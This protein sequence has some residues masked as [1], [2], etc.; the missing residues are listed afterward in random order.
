M[1]LSSHAIKKRALELGFS[2][3][4]VVP[5][6]KLSLESERLRRWL[7]RGF[8]GTM[9]WIAHSFEKRVDPFVHMPD[10]R[11]IVCVALNYYTDHAMSD[12]PGRGKVSRYAWGDDY[13]DIVG[14]RL[15]TLLSWIQQEEP[16]SHGKIAIDTSPVMD[17]AWAAKAGLG[18]IGKHSNLI[19]T[20]FG[21]WV[22]LGE[23]LLNL[24][25]DY[26]EQ[27]IADQCGTCTACL[28]ACPTGA[29]VEPYVVDSNHC[30]S[31][32]TIES[33]A[34]TLAVDTEGWIYGCDICQDVCPWN[35]APKLS[36]E[37]RFQPRPEFLNP[38]LDQAADITSEEFQKLTKKS[39]IRRT[40]YSGWIR[41]ASHTAKSKA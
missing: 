5:A 28:D 29:I 11:S 34:G 6:E 26:D 12:S 14:E 40:R 24:E 17:K 31:Y 25:L 4:G 8:A 2:A 7:N 35:H 23:L 3:A 32:Q 33:R 15:R 16:S 38:A 37:G 9:G 27:P 39:A 10:V 41:N 18:W 1:A 19:H 22:F 36:T 20:T 21:S 13:H 30:I